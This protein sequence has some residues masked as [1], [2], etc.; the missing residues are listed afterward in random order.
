V[1]KSAKKYV[2]RQT[3]YS[4][5]YEMTGAGEEDMVAVFEDQE[6]VS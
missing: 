6:K 2:S 3:G 5:T 4:E 1:E